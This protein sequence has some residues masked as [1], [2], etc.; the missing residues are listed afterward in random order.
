MRNSGSPRELPVMPLAIRP[1]RAAGVL[2][3]KMFQ[4][5]LPAEVGAD[6]TQQP[7]PVERPAP[8]QSAA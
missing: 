6:A 4:P 2:W 7:K 8:W 3:P 1:I 5:A